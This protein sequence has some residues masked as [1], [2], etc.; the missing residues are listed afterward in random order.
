MSQN[1]QAINSI[2]SD[3]DIDNEFEDYEVEYEDEGDDDNNTELK[4]KTDKLSIKSE[5]EEKLFQID[6]R[7]II[8][9][10][11]QYLTYSNN[12]LVHDKHIKHISDKN[13]FETDNNYSAGA[14]N[15]FRKIYYK[16]NNGEKVKTNT[17]F[18]EAQKNIYN[19]CKSNFNNAFIPALLSVCGEETIP[20]GIFDNKVYLQALNGNLR[21][22]YG[23]NTNHND[24]KLIFNFLSIFNTCRIDVHDVQGISIEDIVKVWND[25]YNIDKVLLRH[26]CKVF[27][28]QMYD[29]KPDNLLV[30]IDRKAQNNEEVYFV[31]N[32]FD[33]NILDQAIHCIFNYNIKGK[34]NKD[35]NT[36]WNKHLEQLVKQY[37]ALQEWLQQNNKLDTWNEHLKELVAKYTMTID[38]I[39]NVII[40]TTINA[41]YVNMKKGDIIISLKATIHRWKEML[42][43]EKNGNIINKIP[44]IKDAR[45]KTLEELKKIKDKDI[46]D[47]V[48]NVITLR[49]GCD[50]RIYNK[51]DFNINDKSKQET[52]NIKQLTNDDFSINYTKKNIEDI[53]PNN[54]VIGFHFKKRYNNTMKNK[55]E[56]EISKEKEIKVE[57]KS[58][59][60]K[61]NQQRIEILRNFRTNVKECKIHPSNRPVKQIHYKGNKYNKFNVFMSNIQK[62]NINKKRKK[63]KYNLDE[64]A[65]NIKKF[66]Y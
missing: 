60:K 4:L 62:I 10:L 12:K 11:N 15:M 56:K 29:R 59:Q 20:N 16:A 35:N 8:S 25:D 66:L 22:L 54:K 34:N 30:G 50:D 3:K 32:D 45:T 5:K 6:N 40:K 19:I 1:L 41:K 48:N 27:L 46:E 53:V 65:K 42:K 2:K 14:F 7:N 38:K 43:D 24:V 13:K 57:E 58:Q 61:H 9:G 23:T 55:K 26:L 31:E 47:I 37:E 51:D 63:S 44:Y 64:L 28:L 18:L 52:N 49:D 36:D 39:R 21:D 33:N 17:G